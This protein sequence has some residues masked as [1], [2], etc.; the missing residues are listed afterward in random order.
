MKQTFLT[1]LFSLSCF[2]PA[3]KFK[4]SDFTEGEGRII[5]AKKTPIPPQ[6]LHKYG[7]NYEL[8]TIGHYGKSQSEFGDLGGSRQDTGEAATRR[9]RVDS[10]MERLQRRRDGGAHTSSR[11]SS[12]GGGNDSNRGVA[13]EAVLLLGI[14]TGLIG[15]AISRTW[16]VQ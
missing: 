6:D 4:K 14:I 11:P 15:F 5:V 12:G 9:R 2:R 1:P 13:A 10:E 3:S 16:P 8:W 7:Y